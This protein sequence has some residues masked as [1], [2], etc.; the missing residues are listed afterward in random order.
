VL[1]E[2]RTYEAMPG[3]M[4]ALHKRFAEVTLKYFAQYGIEVV[5]FWTNA[6]GGKSNQLI[7]M[8]RFDDMADREEKW[9]GFIADKRRQALFIESEIEGPLVNW[10]EAHFLTPTPYSPM[11]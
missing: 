6:I 4:P 3:R 11:Q 1:Y 2:L 9:R 8:L 10:T 7:Y 5:A